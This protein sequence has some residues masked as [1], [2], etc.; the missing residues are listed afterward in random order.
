MRV[1]SPFLTGLLHPLNLLMLGLS[2]FAGLVSAWWLFPVGLLF[3]LVMVVAV[4]RDPSLRISHQMQR[5]A[6]LAQRFQRYFDR[7]E[8][9]QVGVF[10]SLASAPSR[11]RRAIQPVQ[12]EIDVLVGQ[13]HALCQRMTTL[14]NYRLVSQSRADLQADLEQITAKIEATDDPLIRREYGESR[15]SLKER[16]DKNDAVSTLLEC[17]EAQLMSLTNELDSIVTEVIRLQAVGPKDAARQVPELVKR[18][19]GQ[20]AQ[21]KEFGRETVRI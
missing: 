13:V 12:S 9:S 15:Q 7:I 6:P 17:V 11:T 1:R 21:L 10:N 2:V 19:R 8:R 4:A 3:W 20:S 16:L 14:E 5:R 18:L